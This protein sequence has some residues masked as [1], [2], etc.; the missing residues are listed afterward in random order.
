MAIIEFDINGTILSANENFLATVGYSLDEIV[1]KHHR[2]FLRSEDARSSEYAT[3]WSKL[4]S[5]EFFSGQFLR[6]NKRGEQV[7]IQA[8]YNPVFGEDGQVKSIVKFASDVTEQKREWASLTS[9]LEAVNRCFAVIEFEV[10]GTII[11]ANDNFLDTV[12]YSMSEIQGKHHSMFAEA[13][14]RNSPEYSEFWRSLGRGEHHAGEYKRVGKGGKEVYIQASYNP[15][16]GLNGEITSVIKFATNV[17]EAVV[18]RKTTTSVAHSVASSVS[19][20]TQTIQEIS[21]NVSSTASLAQDAENL[22]STAKTTVEQ[23]DEQSRS[24]GKVVE[25]IRELAE[26]T[27]LLALNATIESARAGEAGRGFAVVASEVKEL[28]KQ[29]AKATQ[30]IEQTVQLIQGSIKGVV[31]SA[32]QISNSVAS[33]SQ[34]MVVIS[35][36]V[37][38]QSVTMRSLADTA[39]ELQR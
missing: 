14:W 17:T 12:G 28:A 30:S 21:G 19:Q 25:T 22:A 6:V 15:V 29:T 18:N 36:A 3:F 32:E 9:Q 8:T 13:S 27:N 38:E 20:M 5:G 16:F 37:E 4:R 2:M 7:W 11:R 1:G 34:N 24:I 26:Q 35:A 10:D 33:V 31:G 23:L 39:Q